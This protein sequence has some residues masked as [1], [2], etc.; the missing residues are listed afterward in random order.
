MIR[1]ICLGHAA[2][3]SIYR[4]S[5][6]PTEPIKVFAKAYTQCGGGMAANASVAAARLGAEAHYWGRV[7]GD[8][9]GSSIVEQLD[10]ENVRTS[11]V[12]HLHGSRSSTTAI[13]VDDNGERLICVYNDAFDPDAAWLPTEA[14]RGFDVVL[15]DVRWPEGSGAVM[16]AARAARVPTVFDGDIGD[17]AALVALARLAD[18]AIFSERGLAAASGSTEAGLGL[19]RIQDIAGGVVAVT[20]GGDG[21]LWLDHG[22]ERRLRPPAIDAVD[23]LA[24][25][26]VFHAAFAVRIAE[27]G[28]VEVAARFANAAA[29][30]KCLRFGGRLGAPSRDEVEALLLEGRVP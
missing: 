14:V 18:Y 15:A 10:A 9:I 29:A 27:T 8:P 4:V 24:A 11:T 26:D 23:T 5:T 16:T 13:L 19:H 3:D 12:R 2:M 17:P 21:F 1:I 28:D 22:R 25:G 6:I 20:L 30:L 7:G